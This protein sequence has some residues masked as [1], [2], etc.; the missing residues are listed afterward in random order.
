M[1]STTSSTCKK[2]DCFNGYMKDDK[3]SS[4][5]IILMSF[6]IIIEIF[7]IMSVTYFVTKHNTKKNVRIRQSN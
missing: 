7:I 6:A 4:I 5:E 2:E 1:S 3:C